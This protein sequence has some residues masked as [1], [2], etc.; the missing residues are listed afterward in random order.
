MELGEKGIK[1]NKNTGGK[2]G[3]YLCHYLYL[4][5]FRANEEMELTPMFA[6]IN[7]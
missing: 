2:V 4:P 6:F 1:G 7:P 3:H 5:A